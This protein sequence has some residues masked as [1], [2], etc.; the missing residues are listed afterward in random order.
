[1]NLAT[2]KVTEVDGNAVTMYF[3][4]ENIDDAE[5]VLK[6]ST[7]ANQQFS[8]HCLTAI[9][10]Y[11][12]LLTSP[13]A[14]LISLYEGQVLFSTRMQAFSD[15]HSRSTPYGETLNLAL[16]CGKIRAYSVLPLRGA[17]IRVRVEF[18]NVSAAMRAVQLYG[19]NVG[20]HKYRVSLRCYSILKFWASSD[21][22][23]LQSIRVYTQH[24]YATGYRPRPH[25]SI[26][27]SRRHDSVMPQ[28]FENL[29]LVTLDS[30]KLL[31]E[32]LFPLSSQRRHMARPEHCQPHNVLDI[33]KVEAGVDVRTTVSL[34]RLPW[35]SC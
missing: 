20:G 17:E 29:R 23:S 2:E 7:L 24:Y 10:F 11:N 5:N 22:T 25:P 33:Q 35:L 21:L 28:D 3:F 13:R 1:M 26:D 32:P 12:H 15:S 34:S 16:S 6:S 31:A 8:K 14:G 18:V 30:H 27:S 9:Q 19:H 4:F